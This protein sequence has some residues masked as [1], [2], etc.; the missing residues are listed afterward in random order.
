MTIMI[1]DSS[2]LLQG[3]DLL[4]LM[5]FTSV[6]LVML[7]AEWG[8]LAS[9]RRSTGVPPASSADQ[10]GSIHDG[11]IMGFSGSLIVP[12]IINPTDYHQ[13]INDYHDL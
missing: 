5:V 7:A 1:Y 4:L 6:D 9:H 11:T 8:G 12:M 10:F 13:T 2:V 3:F